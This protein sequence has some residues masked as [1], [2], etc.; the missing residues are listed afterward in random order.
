[1][2]HTLT[3]EAQALIDEMAQNGVTLQDL[4]PIVG[5]A[6][7]FMAAAESDAIEAKH[8]QRAIRILRDMSELEKFEDLLGKTLIV[9][10]NVGDEELVFTLSNGDKY[11]LYHNQ[12]CCESVTIEDIAGELGDL[13]GMPLLL[14]EEVIHAQENPKGIG[15]IPQYQDSFTWTFYKLATNR[16]AVTIRWYGS[17]NGWYSERVSFARC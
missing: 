4:A 11:R 10:E 15:E 6:A 9:I 12:N 7:E 3:L 8:V 17:S 1:M 2:N 14:A 5:L 13:V 16:G